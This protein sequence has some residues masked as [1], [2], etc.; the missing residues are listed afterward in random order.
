MIINDHHMQL[1]IY[2]GNWSMIITKCLM[3]NEEGRVKMPMKMKDT[4]WWLSPMA[5]KDL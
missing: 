4:D 1:S 5:F 3:W 2:D